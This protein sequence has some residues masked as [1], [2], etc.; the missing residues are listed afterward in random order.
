MKSPYQ[1]VLS[2]YVTEKSRVLEQLHAKESNKSLRRCKNPK[3]VF[4]VSKDANKLE[5][6][7][8][9]EKIYAEKGVKVVSVNTV[10]CKPKQKRVRG[11][12]G[13][14]SSF[15]KAVVTLAPGNFIDE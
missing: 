1:T 12:T 10:N 11:R 7:D 3:Y 6:A 9:V 15:K 8:A 14:T 2:R 13:W 4:L 5:I